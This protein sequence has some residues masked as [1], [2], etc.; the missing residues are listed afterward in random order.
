M[1]SRHGQEETA[2]S[3]E[4]L[5]QANEFLEQVKAAYQ[6]KP[7]IYKELFCLLR[8]YAVAR[9][10][11]HRDISTQVEALFGGTV[12]DV[13]ELRDVLTRTVQMERA[14]PYAE[15]LVNSAI[16][17]TTKKTIGSTAAEDSTEEEIEESVMKTTKS[18]IKEFAGFIVDISLFEGFS[19]LLPANVYLAAAG[20]TV[21]TGGTSRF[22]K[23]EGKR[24][25]NLAYF[26]DNPEVYEGYYM[27]IDDFE[28]TRTR[29]NRR[30][31]VKTR[32]LLKDS[33]R[34]FERFQTFMPENAKGELF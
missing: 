28:M 16:N 5:R 6:K 19:K 9:D 18:M 4:I 25:M 30:L 13:P 21:K 32:I 12:I 20:H 11:A 14:T 22:H 17:R 34:L 10:D 29:E 3:A 33:P 1:E 27:A 24:F 7:E 31:Y 15:A 26:S 2:R 8:S 23:E